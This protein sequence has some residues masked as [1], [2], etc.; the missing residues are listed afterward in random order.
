MEVSAEVLVT[1]RFGCLREALDQGELAD[2]MEM[3]ASSRWRWRC[4][5]H[6]LAAL[7]LDVLLGL[8]ELVVRGIL[9]EGDLVITISTILKVH[10]EREAYVVLR[11]VEVCWKSS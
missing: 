8:V 6:D 4:R 2:L 10:G 5:T 11:H 9:C 1:W 7:V 3:L